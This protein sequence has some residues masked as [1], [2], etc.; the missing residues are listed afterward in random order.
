MVAHI[1]FRGILKRL[2][3]PR[4]IAPFAHRLIHH[5]AP[6]LALSNSSVKGAKIPARLGFC[7]K[8]GH[9][10]LMRRQ[11]GQIYPLLRVRLQ[12]KQLIGIQ[13]TT[14]IFPAPI[15]QRH[16][17]CIRAF[18]GVFHQHGRAARLTT[19]QRHQVFTGCPRLQ[20]VKRYAGQ[21]A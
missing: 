19:R 14:V 8:R 1:A 13:Q 21:I 7:P 12:I 11:V 18:C 17:R 10:A 16:Q 20:S 15:A 4:V 3:I 9:C 2:V 5:Q 6:R